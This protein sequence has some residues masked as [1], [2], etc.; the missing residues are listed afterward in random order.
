MGVFSGVLPV[1][2]RRHE[3]SLGEIGILSSLSI[4]WSLKVLWSPLIDRYT[5]RRTW[6]A[7]AQLTLGASLVV[8]AIGG[9]PLSLGHGL[10]LALGVYCVAS[11]TQD[12]AIDAYTI[13]LVE[14]G[15]EGPVNSVRSVAYRAGMIAAGWLLFLPDRIGWSGTFAIGAFVSVAMAASVA[16]VPRVPGASAA[17]RADPWGALRRFA[18]RSDVVQ[19]GAFIFLFR[20]GDLAMGPMVTPF[21]TDR[22][23]SN[24]EI[25]WIQNTVGPLA[26]VAGAIV[27]GAGV[28]RFGIPR[29]LIA[30]GV[31]ALAS[32]LS[33]AAAALAPDAALRPAVYTA[34]IVESFCSGLAGVAFMSFL[35]RLCDKE[36]AAVQYASLTAIYGMGRFLVAI[37]S[38]FAAEALG[39]AGYFALTAVLALPAFAFLPAAS[40]ATRA[41]ESDAR[42][43]QSG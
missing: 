12:I 35:M 39:Y 23:F 9:D 10:W 17:A 29:S 3:V 28:H 16:A 42:A 33:Y 40:R 32:N 31:L 13:G 41:T 43:S 20:L 34:S 25:T 37:P 14:R 7:A 4:A 26:V 18:Q 38:G 36:H 30:V 27:A 24:D 6:I 19:L 1:F 22:G 21:W 5:E 15:E 11:A 8:L 2:L